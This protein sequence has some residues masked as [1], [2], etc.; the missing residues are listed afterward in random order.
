MR[1]IS[2]PSPPAIQANDRVI[3]VDPFFDSRPDKIV[4]GSAR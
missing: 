4:A 1:R 2:T 3:A